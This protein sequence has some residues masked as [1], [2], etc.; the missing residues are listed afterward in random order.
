[1]NV[2]VL[3]ISLYASNYRGGTALQTTVIEGFSSETACLIAAD[4]AFE[5][6]AKV[7]DKMGAV[8]VKK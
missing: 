6:L 3:I 2:W 4:Q 1:M 8:C 5:R 7:G